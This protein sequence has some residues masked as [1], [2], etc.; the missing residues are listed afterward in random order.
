[1]PSRNRGVWSRV[2]SARPRATTASLRYAWRPSFLNGRLPDL[3]FPGSGAIT[4]RVVDLCINSARRGARARF[5]RN[6]DHW[7]ASP[8]LLSAWSPCRSSD[9]VLSDVFY[10]SFHTNNPTRADRS[11]NRRFA[12]SHS[13]DPRRDYSRGIVTFGRGVV[14]KGFQYKRGIVTR[15]GRRRQS[16]ACAARVAHASNRGQTGPSGSDG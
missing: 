7:P 14:P 1:M 9:C 6:R 8:S 2:G 15:P 16:V 12:Q 13:F 4:D 5:C 10:T 11:A 3:P